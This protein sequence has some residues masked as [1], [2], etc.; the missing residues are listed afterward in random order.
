[1][2]RYG[3]LISIM[4][5]LFNGFLPVAYARSYNIDEVRIRA[6]IQ[7]NGDLL[8]NEIFTYSFEGKYERVKRFIHEKH[9]QGVK[10]FESYELLNSKAELGYIKPAELS[11]LPLSQEDNGYYSSL[12]VENEQ[13]NLFYTYT[14][15]QAVQSYETYSDLTVPF[16]GGS[17]NHDEDYSRVTI[18]FVFPQEMD[19]AEY[20]AYFHDR[21]GVVEQKG[22]NVV[23]FHTAVSE[24]Y[25]LTE[26]RL[27]FPAEVMSGQT[28]VK[29]P[30]SLEAALAQ[31]DQNLQ[32]MVS[33]SQY[34]E[35]LG[36][37]FIVFA[38]LLAAACLWMI[39]LPQR[40]L[41]RGNSDELM[42]EDPL[43]LYVLD[44]LGKKDSYAFLAGLYS[45]V[46]KGFVSVSVSSSD[47][48]FIQDPEAP[49]QTLLFVLNAD[50]HSLS[51]S[52]SML[53]KALFKSRGIKQRTFL[54]NDLA[55][56][57]KRE[58]KE[59]VS[60]QKYIS[61]IQ[62]FK[63]KEAVWWDTVIAEMKDKRI[64]SNKVPQLLQRLLSI[65]AYTSVL[66]TYFFDSLD[67]SAIA[68]YAISGVILFIITLY[69]P[70]TRWPVILF[71]GVTLFATLMVK[72]ADLLFYLFLFITSSIVLLSLIPRMLL[73]SN[74]TEMY[75]NI[76]SFRKQIKAG[77]IPDVELEKSMVRAQL[78]RAKP[79]TG[80]AYPSMDLAAAAPFAYL[81]MSDQNPF[82]YT[83]DS[84]KMTLPYA[85]GGSG[86]SGD[87]GGS[88]G[89][90]GDGGGG[91]GAD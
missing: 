13:K 29:E 9:H 84:W 6:W 21:N 61:K 44:R 4:I 54:L 43:Y 41:R 70:Y 18:D 75:R 36:S 25:S 69:K 63:E 91:A 66:S 64:I 79:Q 55:G 32:S 52:E 42:K 88:G 86:Y 22:P 31:E 47:S 23:R 83:V 90:G 85:S 57:T 62:A 7:P 68:L 27:L 53:V 20:H 65:M 58:K 56:A 89:G 11:L 78:L 73:S 3:M 49:D 77:V 82:T 74:A 72:D 81:M 71:W 51:D 50:K 39:L 59:K 45:L 5:M 60:F 8:V 33:K 19:P 17:S 38:I 26:T 46:E 2:K 76:K 80:Q 37:V 28:K 24:M 34:K 48:R 10:D 14:L 1:M 40:R 12:S 15:A 16:F 35:K 67:V 87:G 30:M